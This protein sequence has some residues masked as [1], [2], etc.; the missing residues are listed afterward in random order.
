MRIVVTGIGCVTPIGIG[1]ANFA[2]ALREGRSGIGRLSI[3]DPS[4]HECRVAGQ[5]E[6]FQPAEFMDVREARSLPRVA[7]L[8][9]AAARLAAEDAGLQAHESLS[10][11]GVIVGTSSGPI[12]Y[13]LE[14]FGIFFEKGIRRV[15]PSTPAYGHNGVVA[16]ECAIQLGCRGPVFALS[17]ACTSSADAIGI[18]K[19]LIEAGVADV[20]LAGGADAPICPSVL[21]GFERLGMLPRSFNDEPTRAARPFDRHREGLVLGEGSVMLVLERE[22]HAHARNAAAL[23]EVAGYGL[24][25]DAGSHFKQQ[26]GGEEAVRAIRLAL[27]A[28]GVLPGN[29]DYINAHGT[30]TIEN[31]PFESRVIT[32]VLGRRAREVPVSSSK[33]QFGHL[34]GAAGAAEA[35]ATIVGMRGGFVPPTLNL[36]DPD[37][38]CDLLHVPWVSK[39]H[40]VDVALSTSFGFGSRNAALVFRRI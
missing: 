36:D 13:S 21:A 15:H 1:V 9:V 40:V 2:R 8:A 12:A 39:G 16:S 38:E 30:G 19:T 20:V 7:Q 4:P 31:D 17:S 24:T 18:A 14:Q 25:C 5:V 27:G 32:R 23:V 29:V 6:D 3:C 34:L 22:A 35:A 33:S 11:A 37:P 10:R 26:E 28:A